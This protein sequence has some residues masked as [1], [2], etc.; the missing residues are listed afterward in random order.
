MPGG[1]E[2]ERDSE[3]DEH[4]KRIAAKTFTQTN[5]TVPQIR[6]QKGTHIQRADLQVQKLNIND[7]ATM[8]GGI[9]WPNKVIACPQQSLMNYTMTQDSVMTYEH[10][11]E[12]WNLK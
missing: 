7:E 5:I 8:E 10:P 1:R 6:L 2:R 4:I 12:L 3:S 9:K 11:L